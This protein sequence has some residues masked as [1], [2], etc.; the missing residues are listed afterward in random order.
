MPITITGKSSVAALQLGGLGK[1]IPRWKTGSKNTVNFAVFENRYPKQE[2]A[3][4][5]ANK[6]KEAADEWNYLELGVQFEWVYKIV[7]AAFVLS[8]AESNIPGVIA[9]AF[10]PND[11]DLNILNYLKNVF[12]HELG[13]ILGL[14]HEFAPEVEDGNK[15]GMKSLQ[16]GPR[17]PTS[18][19]A[20]EFPPT[21]QT[22]DIDS[23]QA[24]YHS[25]G[26]GLTQDNKLIP[27]VDYEANN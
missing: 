12:L 25:S 4:L 7:D 3:F 17:N 21:I 14:R 11:L 16:F 10:F 13:H 23:A 19:M 9:E 8:Y 20:Y 5:A 24:F 26:K 27:I 6:L 18:V 2:L 22:S 1:A 15:T